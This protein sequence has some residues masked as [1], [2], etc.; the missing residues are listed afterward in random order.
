MTQ[1]KDSETGMKKWINTSN[2]RVREI[3]YQNALSREHDII[4][5][6]K[7]SKIDHANISLQSGYIK[8]LMT[9]FKKR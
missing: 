5:T 4:E 6:F 3:Y 1:F 7:R 9:L 2:Q 8:P